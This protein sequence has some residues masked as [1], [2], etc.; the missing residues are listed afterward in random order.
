MALRSAVHAMGLRYRLFRRPVGAVRRSADL[1][2]IRSRVAVFLDGCF[3]HGCPAHFVLPRTNT[4]YWEA[5]IAGNMRRDA[6]TDRILSEAGWEVVRVWE[7]VPATE[8]AAS[9][10]AAVRRRKAGQTASARDA[11]D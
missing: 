10:A 7:H 8:G 5:K 2:F 9:V 4:A 6:D 3:W 1:V 11:S